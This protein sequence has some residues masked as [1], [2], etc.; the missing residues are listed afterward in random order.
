MLFQL[1]I[2]DIILKELKGLLLSLNVELVI[3]KPG[4]YLTFLILTYL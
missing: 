4:W 1:L 2:S 3:N